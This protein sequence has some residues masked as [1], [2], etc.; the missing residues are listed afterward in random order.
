ML[1]GAN[2]AGLVWIIKLF[3]KGWIHDDAVIYQITNSKKSKYYPWSIG[4]IYYKC[5]AKT[6]KNS[7]S[8]P[9]TCVLC[10]I[11]VLF[12]INKSTLTNKNVDFIL[13]INVLTFN[14][15]CFFDRM[16]FGR[17]IQ[18]VSSF[19]SILQIYFFLTENISSKARKDLCND[20]NTIKYS[21]ANVVHVS[22]AQSNFPTVCKKKPVH[23]DCFSITFEYYQFVEVS[24]F[25]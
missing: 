3:Q 20:F 4:K 16:H 2:R 6:Q 21:N 10:A 25:V 8:I 22:S 15:F 12:V 17:N 11:C 14:L 24:Y 9:C 19:L 13:D 1:C 5:N 23:P 7:I 18:R